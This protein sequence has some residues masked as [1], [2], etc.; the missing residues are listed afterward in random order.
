MIL[1][2]AEHFRDSIL[3][4]IS[5][6]IPFEYVPHRDILKYSCKKP[7][8]IV[9]GKIQ[10]YIN[11][12]KYAKTIHP[13]SQELF[14]KML[15]DVCYM[16]TQVEFETLANMCGSGYRWYSMTLQSKISLRGKMQKVIGRAWDIHKF[17][18]ERD[19]AIER[20]ATD[21]MTGIYNKVT[22][23][24]KIQERL[25]I[26]GG[27]RCAMLMIDLD[28]FKCINDH[29]GHAVGDEVLRNVAGLHISATSG[30]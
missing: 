16:N 5:R 17:I 14:I 27:Q 30:Q 11:D 3:K 13:E 23:A 21:M 15:K 9:N 22:L 26:D 7:N 4:Q 19:L 29:Y 8:E 12:K 6:E 25:K 24:E 20:A 1:K 28:N 2:K 18:T 10:G